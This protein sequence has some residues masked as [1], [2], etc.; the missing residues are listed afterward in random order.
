MKKTVSG[1][2]CLILLL[3]SGCTGGKAPGGPSPNRYQAEFLSLFDTVTVIVG[4]S[5]SEESFRALAEKTRSLLEEYHKLYDI[6]NTYEGINNIKTINDNAGVAPVEVDRRIIDLLKL[7]KQQYSATG[8]AINVAFGA[9]LRLWHDYRTAGLDD[10]ESARLPP[11]ELLEQAS[12]HT[13]IEDMIIDEAASTVYLKDPAMSLDVGAVAKGYA[14]EQVAAQLEAQGITSLLLSVGGN[15]RAIGEKPAPDS[16]GDRRWVIGI[17]NPD[18]SSPQSELMQ[19]QIS[20]LAVVS[21]GSYERY[22]TVDGVRYSHII[23]P[24]TLMPA[25]YYS[26]VT[27]IAPDSGLCDVLSTAAFVKPL[28]ESRR[29]IEAL[30]GVEALWV[31]PDGSIEFSGGFRDYLKAS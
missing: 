14:T 9:V 1:L 13:N 3:T 7:A 11:M 29:L 24:E 5:D 4:Y 25:A 2:L 17:Q 8:G 15:V 26:D 21:S 20:D 16:A 31:L 27:I 18:K 22:Y 6:Y 10:P 30:D 19:V 23:D 12:R 28:E